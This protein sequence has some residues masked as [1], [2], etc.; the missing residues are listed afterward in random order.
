MNGLP[1]SSI[2]KICDTMPI[3]YTRTLSRLWRL[4]PTKLGTYATRAVKIMYLPT[5]VVLNFKYIFE[6][7]LRRNSTFLFHQD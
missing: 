3:A 5:G 2:I 1:S 7:F 6:A 4:F